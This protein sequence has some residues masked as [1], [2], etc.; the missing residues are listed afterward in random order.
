MGKAPTGTPAGAHGSGEGLPGLPGGSAAGSPPASAGDPGGSSVQGDPTSRRITE[1]V[2]RRYGANAP[3]PALRKRNCCSE[4]ARHRQ[5]GAQL[6]PGE[7]ARG[8]SKAKGKT[9]TSFKKRKSCRPGDTALEIQK[10]MLPGSRL[11]AGT[12]QS[13]GKSSAWSLGHTQPMQRVTGDRKTESQLCQEST[14][15]EESSRAEGPVNSKQLT[16]ALRACSTAGWIVRAGEEAARG[17]QGPCSRG[18]MTW[19]GW[20]AC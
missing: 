18:A 6:R 12:I 1:P 3:E 19:S 16:D 2:H 10:E 14:T 15:L 17:R 20:H 5:R 13:G 8:R 11:L 7:K 4:P 9:N